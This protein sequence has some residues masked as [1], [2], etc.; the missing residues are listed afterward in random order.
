LFER[1]FAAGAVTHIVTLNLGGRQD[2]FRVHAIG[3]VAFTEAGHKELAELVKRVIVSVKVAMM[4]DTYA[5]VGQHFVG[6][7][8]SAV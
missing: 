3:L 4:W 8:C 2:V 1:K 7:L 6:R 5:I